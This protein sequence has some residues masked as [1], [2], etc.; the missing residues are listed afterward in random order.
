MPSRRRAPERRK[1]ARLDDDRIIIP[2]KFLD[3]SQIDHRLDPLDSGGHL[4]K[5]AT[6]EFPPR[7]PRPEDPLTAWVTLAHLGL[8]EEGAPPLHWS[9]P[10]H[11]NREQRLEA[12][13]EVLSEAE[14]LMVESIAVPKRYRTIPARELEEMIRTAPDY[15]DRMW[16]GC[17][18][19]LVGWAQVGGRSS[20][21]FQTTH[22][23][24]Y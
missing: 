5:I 6:G 23:R 1:V 7:E 20:V 15:I 9:K 2:F 4:M 22:G 16:A 24:C 14:L 3:L 10:Q 19:T 18:L 11:L 17:W 8:I 13:R 21:S 12:A